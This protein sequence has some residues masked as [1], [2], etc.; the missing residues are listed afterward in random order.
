M[1]TVDFSPWIQALGFVFHKS[2]EKTVDITVDNL[3]QSVF[4]ALLHQI[5]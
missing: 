2:V 4:G 5:A 3:R 1:M